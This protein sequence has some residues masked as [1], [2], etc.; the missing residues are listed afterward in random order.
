MNEFDPKQPNAD[1]LDIASWEDEGGAPDISDELAAK[2][3]RIAREARQLRML[4]ET[5]QG[6]DGFPIYEHDQLAC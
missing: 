4:D 2:R 1:S 3:E 6:S 5:L